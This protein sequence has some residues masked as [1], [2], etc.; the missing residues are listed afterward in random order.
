[1][2]KRIPVH[3]ALN[4]VAKKDRIEFTSFDVFSSVR[5]SKK[6]QSFRDSSAVATNF[7]AKHKLGYLKWLCASKDTCHNQKYGPHSK[8][9]ALLETTSRTRITPRN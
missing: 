8:I 3:D 9:L 5:F 1:M 2:Q 7:E 6:L 4:L